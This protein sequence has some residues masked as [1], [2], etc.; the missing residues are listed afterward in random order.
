MDKSPV[1]GPPVV[2][3]PG[4]P[5]SSTGSSLEYVPQEHRSTCTTGDAANL[6]DPDAFAKSV[7]GSGAEV[8][9][10]HILEMY[11]LL[12][13]ERPGLRRTLKTLALPSVSEFTFM[14]GRLVCVTTPGY[15][16]TVLKC[17]VPTGDES[18]L[19]TCSR[20]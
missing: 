2:S 3:Q 10:E 12:P 14:L 4:S 8:S 5:P 9:R 18:C 15:C 13:K 6:C 1:V 17:F 16:Q 20:P 7:L 19:S 11:K